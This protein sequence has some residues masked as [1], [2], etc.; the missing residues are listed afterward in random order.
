MKTRTVLPLLMILA[1]AAFASAQNAVP[2]ELTALDY[3]QIRQL[4][5]R[6]ARAIDTCSNNGYD[7][8]NLFTPDGYFA[9]SINGKAGPKFQGRETLAEASGAVR[10]DE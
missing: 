6:Y 8:A 3:F 2:G 5:A 1:S 7:Y 9:P 10:K 4:V